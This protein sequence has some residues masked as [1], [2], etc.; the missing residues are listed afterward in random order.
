[1]EKRES[2]WKKYFFGP[3]RAW[4]FLGLAFGL[5]TLSPGEAWGQESP[6]S[7]EPSSPTAKPETPPAEKPTP[8]LDELEQTLKTLEQ[9]L[10]EQS[11]QAEKQADNSAKSGSEL[12]DSSSNLAIT[13]DQSQEDSTATSSS[14]KNASTSLDTTGKDFTTYKDLVKVTDDD[15]ATEIG[16]LKQARWAFATA[17]AAT[18]AVLWILA[19]LLGHK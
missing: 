1:M 19:S 7:S 10:N 16:A 11:K 4:F 5:V 9:R 3:W 17:G 14:L 13:L 18:V 6:S 8:I 15:Q 12:T 2:R